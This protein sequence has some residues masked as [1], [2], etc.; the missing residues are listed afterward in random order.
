MAG[1]VV[2]LGSERDPPQYAPRSVVYAAPLSD[3]RK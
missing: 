2:D 1:E 3:D